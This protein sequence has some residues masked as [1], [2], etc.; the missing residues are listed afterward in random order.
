MLQLLFSVLCDVERWNMPFNFLKV[1][2]LVSRGFIE[3]LSWRPKSWNQLSSKG[4]L[5]TPVNGSICTRL[6]R[7]WHPYAGNFCSLKCPRFWVLPTGCSMLR[8]WF[9]FFPFKRPNFAV[10][11][12]FLLT[13]HN[14]G[15]NA[16]SPKRRQHFLVRHFNFASKRVKFW[17]MQRF[18]KSQN[19][20]TFVDQQTPISF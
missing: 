14:N 18:N 4:V 2:G 12:A 10:F 13:F 17:K 16:R 3:T 15:D 19:C 11:S 6:F 5:I 7:T 9:Y 8:I 1:V 20:S